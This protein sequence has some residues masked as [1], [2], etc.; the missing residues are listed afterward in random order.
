[1]RPRA[2]VGIAVVA[3]A[4]LLALAGAAADGPR[5]PL[6]EGR[7]LLELRCGPDPRDASWPVGQGG[8][9]RGG[10]YSPLAQVGASNVARLRVEWTFSSDLLGNECYPVVAGGVA[11]VTTSNGHVHALDAATG[12]RLWSWSPSGLPADASAT[13]YPNR[14]VA[15][16]GGRV[17]AVAPN[18]QLSALDART[19]KELWT[20]GVG[21]PTVYSL[22]SP[23][24][25]WRGVLYLG[26]AGASA[27]ARGYVEA[28]RAGDGSLLWR[29]YT[30]PPPDRPGGYGGGA[31]WMA[32]TLDPARGV[33]YAGTGN[34]WPTSD[35]RGRPGPNRWTDS[36]LAL[37]MRTG[38][39]RWAFQE[40]PHDVWDY[41][42]VSPP[43]LLPG[44]V[45]Q[46]SKGGLWFQLD[47]ARGRLQ[48]PPRPFVK[49]DHPVPR[50]DG[51]AR[52]IWP[53][54]QHGGGSQWSPVAY[55][56]GTGL[57]YVSGINSPDYVRLPRG[58]APPRPGQLFSQPTLL[59]VVKRSALS[60]TFTAFR[61]RGARRAWQR[62]ERLPLVGG[63]TATAGGVVFTAVS[64]AGRL[65]ALDARGGATLG[66]WSLGGRIDTAPSVYSVAGREYV[67]VAVGGSPLAAGAWGGF[68]AGPARF[69][70]LALP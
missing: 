23:P 5:A 44:G 34:P 69:V 40:Q 28:R 11:Y 47:A 70:A 26:G 43:V 31:V 32:P 37:D 65:L 45:G 2:L 39:I 53:G 67:L 27:S 12:R 24:A 55:H 30:I 17:F 8:G 7:C 54:G 41:D 60:G 38:R 18:A 4:C 62:R 61:V 29:R 10:R 1:M 14:G 57:A 58:S 63:A 19:G 21:D 59:P 9:A 16:G 64:G 56:P 15:I 6:V 25:Y 35:G 68:R 49:I 36:V 13:V 52:W 20:V 48:A 66:A 50:P 3:G 22:S 42:A 33:L 46:A 51:R